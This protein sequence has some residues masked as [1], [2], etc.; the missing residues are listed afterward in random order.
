MHLKV[1]VLYD[2]KYKFLV[3]VMGKTK[4]SKKR[5]SCV[6]Q[7]WMKYVELIAG[8]ID[9]LDDVNLQSTSKG[10]HVYKVRIRGFLKI[11]S[12]KIYK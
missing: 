11:F 12:W 2:S 10:S 8:N 3:N 5:F 4:K 6:N 7:S 9:K 1:C